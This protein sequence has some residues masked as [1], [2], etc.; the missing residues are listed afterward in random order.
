MLVQINA[1]LPLPLLRWNLA[2]ISK[3]PHYSKNDKKINGHDD[4]H[5]QRNIQPEIQPWIFDIGEETK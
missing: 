2:Q 4:Q 5:L 3:G 1:K